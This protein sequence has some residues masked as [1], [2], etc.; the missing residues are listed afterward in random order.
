MT[1]AALPQ[2]IDASQPPTQ[3][4]PW[5]QIRE[6][7]FVRTATLVMPEEVY[8]QILTGEDECWWW[9]DAEL[10]TML[11]EG[12][13][14]V[15]D[16]RFEIREGRLR[17][18]LSREMYEKCGLQGQPVT[19]GGGGRK[20]VKARLLHGVRVPEKVAYV[21]GEGEQECEDD[22]YEVVEWL[23]MVALGSDHITGNGHTDSSISRYKVPEG[24]AD[25]K[26]VDLRVVR[27]TGLLSRSWITALLIE[28]LRRS[29]A[30]NVASWLAL[31]VASHRTEAV[32][33]IDGYTVLLQSTTSKEREEGGKSDGFQQSRCFQFVGS[34]D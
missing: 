30:T 12:R 10:V 7:P 25:V 11:S 3:R 32:G 31:S 27:W 28:I 34:N 33:Q 6:T 19:G 4:S 18:E 26:A 17:M 16:S 1:R 8:Q 9:T 22:W 13:P 23:D 29:K 2:Y 24:E 15:D 14:G 21:V 20:H 5:R